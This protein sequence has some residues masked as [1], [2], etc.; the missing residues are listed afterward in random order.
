MLGDSLAYG[1]SERRGGLVAVDLVAMLLA[2]GRLGG[3]LFEMGIEDAGE[4]NEKG[5]IRELKKIR[6]EGCS[7]S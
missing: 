3:P 1:C 5:E 7:R 2:I 4:M 6:L